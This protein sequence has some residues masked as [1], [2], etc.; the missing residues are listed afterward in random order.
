MSSDKV[1]NLSA[2]DVRE[3]AKRLPSAEVMIADISNSIIHDILSERKETAQ[4]PGLE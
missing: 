4:C 2:D 3:W 1:E